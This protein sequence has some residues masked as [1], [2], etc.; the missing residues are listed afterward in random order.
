MINH[1]HSTSAPTEMIERF[2]TMRVENPKLF[3]IRRLHA[4]HSAKENFM[5]P[6]RSA[7]HCF[8]FVTHG[9]T[10][11]MIGDE[12]YLFKA[13]ECAV[14]PAGQMFSVRYYNDCIGFMGGFHTHFLTAD[15]EG[16]SLL[17]TFAFLRKW[18]THKVLFDGQ[19][20]LYV[21]NL[22]E[23]LY[24]ENESDKN[25]SILKAYLT[26]LLVEIDTAE[27][28][29]LTQTSDLSAANTLCNHFLEAVFDQPNLN[30]SI[31]H[32]AEKFNVTQAHLQK[33][34]KSCTGKTPLTW[35]N[36]AVILEAKSLLSHTDIPVNEIAGRVGVLDP[37]YFARIFKKQVGVT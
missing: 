26:T 24:Q 23:R 10:L 22:F 27:R 8:F 25:E 1:P 12:S 15:N 33:T 32:Y 34:V 14:I 16:K 19:S 30:L 29:M 5:P 18:G 37:S 21:A 17:H 35:I 13:N 11:I 7:I 36:E 20:G 2:H 4:T 3:V 31:G 6:V 28:K 9:E